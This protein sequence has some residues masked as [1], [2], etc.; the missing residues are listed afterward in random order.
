MSMTTPRARPN[1]SPT[2]TPLDGVTIRYRADRDRAGRPWA[3]LVA[4]IAAAGLAAAG[5][6]IAE[7]WDTAVTVLVYLGPVAVATVLAVMLVADRV[8]RPQHQ[9]VLAGA[10][11][12]AGLAASVALFV[13][14]MY[15][16]GHDAT[17]T[18]LLAG[19]GLVIGGWSAWLLG[20]R[21]LGRLADAERARRDLV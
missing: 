11:T 6:V 3:G 10:V 14:A 9:L 7:G 13:E 20:S 17:F 1:S 19:Y 18:V 8:T 21:A 5:A 4:A 12:V 2:P 16:S 15:V